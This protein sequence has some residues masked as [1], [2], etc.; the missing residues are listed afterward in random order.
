MAHK[1][2]SR[3]LRDE[4]RKMEDGRACSR[5]ELLVG[6][7]GRML[8]CSDR[9]SAEEAGVLKP[10]AV[11]QLRNSH[12]QMDLNHRSPGAVNVK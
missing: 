11:K 9:S 4:K 7:R 1:E 2:L 3:V 12:L 5:R 6:Q 10:G 8:Y